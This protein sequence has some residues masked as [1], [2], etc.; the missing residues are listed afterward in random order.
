MR[1]A[2][3]FD[4]FFDAPEGTYVRGR[5]WAYFCP[6]ASLYG[7]IFWGRPEV[8]D[9]EPLT[10]LWHVELRPEVLPHAS[11]VDA[12]GMTGMDV[13]WFERMQR[14]L[15][16]CQVQLSERIERQALVRPAGVPGTMVAGFSGV[17]PPAYPVQVFAT[18][19]EALEW[20]GHDGLADELKALVE[21]IGI[22]DPVL[23]ELRQYLSHA[24]DE[25]TL[26][27]AARAAR[28]SE[29]T[30]QRK[31]RDAGTSFLSELQR[32]RVDAAKVLLADTELK[33]TAIALEVGCASLQHFSSL[34]RQMTGAPPSEWRSRHKL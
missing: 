11:Y 2:E 26:A 5:N 28:V 17:V 12:S 16:D 34:F 29:R 21:N 27:G 31:L 19:A 15:H 24:L 13:E 22:H 6:D 3:G 18:V 14:E 23:G 20:V 25:A 10:A 30:L 1:P 9:V 33:L 32:A 7:Q 4:A 8:A